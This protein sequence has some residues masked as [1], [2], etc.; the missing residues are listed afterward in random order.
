MNKIK[1]TNSGESTQ[2]ELSLSTASD[3]EEVSPIFVEKWPKVSEPRSG[4]YYVLGYLAYITAM[5]PV[6][7]SMT[8]IGEV[9]TQNQHYMEFYQR[10]PFHTTYFSFGKLAFWIVLCIIGFSF[11]N[12]VN[13]GNTRSNVFNSRDGSKKDFYK[14]LILVSVLFFLSPIILLR[15]KHDLQKGCQI[16]NSHK[17]IDLKLEI[18]ENTMTTDIQQLPTLSIDQVEETSNWGLYSTWEVA[19]YN[20]VFVIM[21]FIGLNFTHCDKPPF[22]SLSL[23][24]NAISKF[25]WSQWMWLIFAV[26]I[27]IGNATMTLSIYYNA[28]IFRYYGTILAAVITFLILTTLALRKTHS[29]HLHHYAWGAILFSLWGYQSIYVTGLGALWAG[30]MM[31]G[32]SRWG[33]DAIWV[34]RIH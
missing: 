25:G 24:P 26:G 32:I 31:E 4:S 13:L 9:D 29:L 30:I 19:S 2:S 20:Y 10:G 28:G 7:Y 33:F 1:S 27:V 18:I 15:D 14:M 17:F 3:H 16:S 22:S 6:T 5:I 21:F 8:L 12:V 11:V 34:P 23:T